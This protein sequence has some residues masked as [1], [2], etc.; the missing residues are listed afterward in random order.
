MIEQGAVSTC[1]RALMCWVRDVRAP[2]G[3]SRRTRIAPA[4]RR[5]SCA[6]PADSEDATLGEAPAPLAHGPVRRAPALAARSLKHASEAAAHMPARAHARRH[7]ASTSPLNTSV[8]QVGGKL[9]LS[10][11][12]QRVASL[13]MRRRVVQMAHGEHRRRDAIVQLRHIDARRQG[14]GPQIVQVG[15]CAAWWCARAATSMSARRLRAQAARR[16]AARAA[17]APPRRGRP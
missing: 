5:G 6:R 14:Q 3:G 13:Q 10:T 4:R 2:R 9:L 12:V 11:R 15:N 1:V 17:A 16:T 8:Q 7:D